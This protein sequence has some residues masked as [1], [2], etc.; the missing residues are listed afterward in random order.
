MKELNVE[1]GDSVNF[2]LMKDN[3][4]FGHGFPIELNEVF[5]QDI[6]AKTRFELL[7]LGKKRALI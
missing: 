2:Q 5:L 7:S 6:E 3:S 1:A 4:E